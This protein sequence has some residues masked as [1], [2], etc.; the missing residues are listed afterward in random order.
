M[1]DLTAIT[2]RIT[3][4]VGF[5]YKLQCRE[6]GMAE[7]LTMDE[8]SGIDIT[9]ELGVFDPTVL[10][11]GIHEIRV[12]ATDPAGNT[13]R[14][15]TCA[16]VDGGMKLG[17]LEF[18]LEDLSSPQLGMPLDLIRKYDSRAQG[19]SLNDFGPG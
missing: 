17:Q 5:T 13:G 4:N 3:D 19:F 8:G 7:W 14:A 18:A 9:G 6:S 12:I 15:Y 1:T 11:N 16:I 10:R 2:G